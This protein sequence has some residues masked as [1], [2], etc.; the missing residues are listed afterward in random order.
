M[1]CFGQVYN[2]SCSSCCVG[3]FSPSPQWDE[4]QGAARVF[5][6]TG[7]VR[8]HTLPRLD[9]KFDVAKAKQ[10]ARDRIKN[11]QR[12][13]NTWV[14]T[15]VSFSSGVS[16]SQN[17]GFVLVLGLVLVPGSCQSVCGFCISSCCFLFHRS[18]G[19][20][21]VV[22]NMFA[23]QSFC[24]FVLTLVS[25]TKLYRLNMCTSRLAVK[26]TSADDC[27]F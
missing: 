6:A 16:S 21:S 22:L 5:G 3:L 7:W 4:P 17:C 25:A 13:V 24:W 12:K 14:I 15:P 19:S 10:D 18:A 27:I 23:Q 9:N 1:L 20:L 2:R 8:P 11:A 26:H